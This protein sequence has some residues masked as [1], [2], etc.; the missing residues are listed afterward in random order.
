[1]EVEDKKNG[2]TSTGSL[3]KDTLREFNF[4]A[5]MRERTHIRRACAES[6]RVYRRLNADMPDAT[7]RETCERTVEKR[8]GAGVAAMRV[9]R[10]GR[11]IGT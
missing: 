10:H 8:S 2:V 9:S 4:V 1:M 7:K 11:S 3:L 5:L 6:L